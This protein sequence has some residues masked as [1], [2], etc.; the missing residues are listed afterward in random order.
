MLEFSVHVATMVALYG[1]LALSLNLQVGYSGLVN[2]GQIALFG[3][4][5]YGL[6]IAI[7][8]GSGAVLG[9]AFGLV[10]AV[11]LALL[12]ARLGRRL[13][14]DYWGIA[15]LSVAEIVRTFAVNEVWLTGGAQG[16]SN[17]PMLF[18]GGLEPPYDKWALL[19]LC[20]AVLGATC[21]LLVHLTSGRFGRALKLMRDEPNLAASLGYSV[22]GLRR[23]ALVVAAIPAAI[24]GF[25]FASYFT[26]VGPD[27]LVASET[28]L[29]WAMV[30]IG[31]LGNHR[32][33]L[34]G[35][36]A[37]VILFAFV[38]FLKDWL[39]LSSEA[40]GAVRL[41]MLG[42]GLLAFLLWRPDGILPERAGSTSGG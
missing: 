31:G 25:L 41:T 37:I 33:A 42:G 15:T 1:L 10:L 39:G 34:V 27:Q 5:T 6:G 14:A 20:W 38:P 22:D 11:L 19:A 35:A 16:L 13:G 40:L 30:I 8:N 4:G 26:F 24:A 23:Q 12:F 18:G 28:F 9:L 2:F 32:G 36:A 29:I 7:A 17:I 21:L 3:C